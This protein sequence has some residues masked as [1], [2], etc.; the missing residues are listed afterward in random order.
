MI[1]RGKNWC[2]IYVLWAFVNMGSNRRRFI[3]FFSKYLLITSCALKIFFLSSTAIISPK[4][5]EAAEPRIL[6][7]DAINKTGI[8][9]SYKGLNG[10]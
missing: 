10:F 1:S 5:L 9:K 6:I 2:L 8:E 3:L 7:E 4:L